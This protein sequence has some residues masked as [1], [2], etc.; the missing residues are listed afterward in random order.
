M[1][2]KVK[3]LCRIIMYIEFP[4]RLVLEV[5]WWVRSRYHAESRFFSPIPCCYASNI[6]N[7]PLML[8]E[9]HEG[10]VQDCKRGRHDPQVMTMFSF[11]INHKNDRFMSNVWGSQITWSHL[12]NIVML[13]MS[14]MKHCFCFKIYKQRKHWQR[15]RI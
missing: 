13:L 11:C 14:L 5:V 15:A 10:T 2:V 8:N 9:I 1:N 4:Y 6:N 12:F 3:R 7:H